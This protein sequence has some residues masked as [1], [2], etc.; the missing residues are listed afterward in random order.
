MTDPN[1]DELVKERSGRTRADIINALEHCY[2]VGAPGQMRCA[3]DETVVSDIIAELRAA[4]ALSADNPADAL[5]V[6]DYEHAFQ[7]HRNLVR[8]IDVIING[9]AGAAKQASLCDLVG[10]IEELV[11]IRGL[12]ADTGGE[13]GRIEPCKLEPRD[14]AA[15]WINSEKLYYRTVFADTALTRLTAVI[16]RARYDGATVA[17]RCLAPTAGWQLVPVEPTAEMVRAG[18]DADIPGGR[19]GEDTF[20]DSGVDENDIPVIWKDMLAA[21]PSPTTEIKD[22]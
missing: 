15:V 19:W 2:R 22:E 12:S 13:D 18:C 4:E 8:M 6:A 3:I 16:S 17:M 10:Q 5:T 1:R 9:E 11:A 7:S 21:A 14:V 20:H